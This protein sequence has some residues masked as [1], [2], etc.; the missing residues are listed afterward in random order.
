MEKAPR[1]AER[2]IWAGLLLTVLLL[3]LAALLA[4]AKMHQARGPASA[5]PVISQVADFNLTNQAG[6]LV[7]LKDLKGSVWVAD[8]IFTRCAGPCPRMTRQMSQL[9]DALPNDSTAKLVTL[10]TDPKY[11][12]PEVMRAY[13]RKFG[14][15]EG[16]WMFLTGDPREISRLAVDSLKLTAIEKKPQEQESPE[17]LFIH[18]TIFVVVDKQGRLRRVVETDESIAPAEVRQTLLATVKRLEREP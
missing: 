16:R 10:T 5:L 11:D 6:N 9:Q 4:L 18:S 17:D 8:I 12:T 7:T 2:L 1:N 13:G 14:A 3:L 15:D